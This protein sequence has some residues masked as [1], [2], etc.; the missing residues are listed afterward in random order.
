MSIVDVIANAAGGI[1]G[2]KSRKPS[3]A[4]LPPNPHQDRRPLSWD[5]A[6]PIPAKPTKLILERAR[7]YRP[8]VPVSVE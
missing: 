7:R 4:G 3:D 8:G 6:V 1:A 5:D 2:R